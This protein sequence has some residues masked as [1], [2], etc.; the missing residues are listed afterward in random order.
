MTISRHGSIGAANAA[1]CYSVPVTYPLK[2]KE[3]YTFSLVNNQSAFICKLW[4]WLFTVWNFGKFAFFLSLFPPPTHFCDVFLCYSASFSNVGLFTWE[5]YVMFKFIC[6]RCPLYRTLY[7]FADGATERIHG[8]KR[9]AVRGGVYGTGKRASWRAEV[10]F[11][12][13]GFGR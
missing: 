12:C 5:I 13:G 3:M 11:P 8:A 10:S 4:L 9:D 7:L 6:S 1:Y 2:T